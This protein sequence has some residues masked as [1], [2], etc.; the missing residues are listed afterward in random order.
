MGQMFGPDFPEDIALAVSGG[1]DS[2]AML[3]LAA[4]WAHV[5]GVRL[6]VAT[7]DHGLRAES[8]AE[9]AMVAAECKALGLRHST[10]RWGG[11]DGGGNLQDA[12]RAARRDL[13]GRWRG[14]CRHV[15]MAHTRDDQAETLLMRL[16]RGSGVDGLAAMADMTRLPADSA[17]PIHDADGPPRPAVMAPDWFIARPLLET[18]RAALRHYLK[19][20]HIP[21]AD[22]PSNDD[23]AYARVRM[24]RLIGAE[25]LD[26]ATLATTARHMRRAQVALGRRAHDVALQIART[27]PT[28]PGCVVLDRDG[29][30]AT[31]AE[32]QLRLLAAALQ[33]VATATYRPRLTALEDA[34][35]RASG[36]G[37]VTLHG[38]I[39]VPRGDRLW[40]AREPARVATLSAPVGDDTLWDR[41]WALYGPDIKGLQVR[42]LTED[43]LRQI[44]GLP[45][46]R[47]P[48]VV[49]TGLPAVW[50]GDRLVACRP[51]GFGPAYDSDHRPPGGEFPK[52]LLAH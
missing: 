29:F 48:R 33:M 9:A 32:T 27:D 10:L 6:W 4:G 26:V 1:G 21:Y 20:L 35:D 16:A 25:G 47:A 45:R 40:I 52:R 43:G 15:L 50:D 17:P 7:V 38:G 37:I 41:R 11:W 36:G 44:S 5:Y 39:V 49:L 22:D 24:R 23:T 14:V 31:E 2:M 19:T 13:I 3:H 12:A 28:A 46:P 18:D 51:L 30:A 8:A 34:L 42:A